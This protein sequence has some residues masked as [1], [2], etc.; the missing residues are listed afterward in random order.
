[1]RWRDSRPSTNVQDY[2]GRRM[3]RAG[4]GIGGTLI[5]LVAAYFLAACDTFKESG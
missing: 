3:G 2:R 4:L 5:A 1:M